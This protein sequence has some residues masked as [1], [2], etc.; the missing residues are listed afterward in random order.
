MS[1]AM[2]LLAESRVNGLA[3]QH[4]IRALCVYFHS[5]SPS[6]PRGNSSQDTL[7]PS[8]SFCPNVLNLRLSL[9]RNLSSIHALS[10][11]DPLKVLFDDAH[12]SFE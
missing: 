12:L 11:R 8:V 3:S 7:H 5:L 10:N 6:L 9:S 2:L 4:E 1:S